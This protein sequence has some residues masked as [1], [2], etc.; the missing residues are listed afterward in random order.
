MAGW[1]GGPERAHAYA[2]CQRG[3]IDRAE[4]RRKN[5]RRPQK[6]RQRCKTGEDVVGLPLAAST[7][8]GADGKTLFCLLP[9]RR[10]LAHL[11]LFLPR[12]RSVDMPAPVSN[13]MARLD[14]N[15]SRSPLLLYGGTSS[16]FG[17]DSS[18]QLMPNLDSMVAATIWRG[19]GRRPLAHSFDVDRRDFCS[20]ERKPLSLV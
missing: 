3:Q 13:L 11:S 1:R 16:V 9:R 5:R 10:S 7:M 4:R 6:G 2:K 20:F 17:G 18:F 15:V 19:R 14:A 12:H 8:G